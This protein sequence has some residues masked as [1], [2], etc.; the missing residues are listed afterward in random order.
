MAKYLMDLQTIKNKFKTRSSMN[1]KNISAMMEAFP[2]LL[3]EVKNLELK[4]IESQKII[5]KLNKLIKYRP[6][7]SIKGKKDN[8][9]WQSEYEEEKNFFY[10]LFSGDFTY[11]VAKRSTNQ[12]L[13]I[14]P[15]LRKK[16]DVIADLSCMT[17][18]EPKSVFHIK[19]LIYIFKSTDI[20]RIAF[21][22]NKNRPEISSMF[23]KMI[24]EA[25]I[26][27][28]IVKDIKDGKNTF[29]NL[30]RFLKP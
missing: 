4:I 27:F 15:N 21:V 14:L 3:R 13:T 1:V 29:E 30:S 5:K 12:I 6:P 18:F 24:K 9:Q 7:L 11:N 2:F 26:N 10:I 25:D 8:A 23:E 19:K 28:F 20:N 22:P 16:F 17:S